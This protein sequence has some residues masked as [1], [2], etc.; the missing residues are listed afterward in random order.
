VETGTLVRRYYGRTAVDNI[1]RV[2]F[3]GEYEEFIITGSESKL[4]YH[5]MPV[6]VTR[7]HLAG[8]GFIWDRETGK[9]LDEIPVTDRRTVIVNELSWNPVI[10]DLIASAD[11][12]GEVKTWRAFNATVEA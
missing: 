12:N 8:I 2:H 6:K 7:S 9:L 4:F 11:D 3:G 5:L 1:I 10:H